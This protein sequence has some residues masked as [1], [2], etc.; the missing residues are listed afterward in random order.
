MKIAYHRRAPLFIILLVYLFYPNNTLVSQDTN[1]HPGYLVTSNLDTMRGAIVYEDRE[2]NPTS[3]TIDG[4]N[5]KPKEISEVLIPG[6]SKWV[7]TVLRYPSNPYKLDELTESKE[8]IWE[9][10]VVLLRA[11]IEGEVGLYELVDDTGKKHFVIWTPEEGF[12]SLIQLKYLEDRKVGV[13]SSYR[14]QLKRV[15]DNVDNFHTDINR[16]SYIKSNLSKLIEK[17]HH[18]KGKEVSYQLPDESFGIDISFRSG[19]SI[20]SHTL[21]SVKTVNQNINF[22]PELHVDFIN[23]KYNRNWSVFASLGYRSYSVPLSIYN[24]GTEQLNYIKLFAG[25]KRKY[26]NKKFSVSLGMS[27]A[28]L[29]NKIDDDMRTYEVGVFFGAGFYFDKFSLN[30]RSEIANGYTR[31]PRYSTVVRSQ[32]ITLGYKF[33]EKK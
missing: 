21:N 17:Y 8:L 24:R 27:N 10:K 23:P 25:L 16:S 22:S 12:L 28:D 29:I 19:I 32:Y 30:L 31:T 11:I 3:I 15:L 7:S 4:Q 9:E 13:T 26:F 33:Y 14:N 5:Y 18:K 2:K 1:L 6:K 20:T